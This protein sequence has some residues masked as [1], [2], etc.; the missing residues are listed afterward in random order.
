[1][2]HLLCSRQWSKLLDSGYTM[3]NKTGNA[4]CDCRVGNIFLSI[5]IFICIIIPVYLFL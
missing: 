5:Y 1:M 2:K 3:S 4:V